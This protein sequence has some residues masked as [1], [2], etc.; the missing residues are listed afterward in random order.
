MSDAGSSAVPEESN[1]PRSRD[2]VA[3]TLIVAIS[4]SLVCSIFVSMSAVLLKPQ[5]IENRE[6]YRKQ[7]AAGGIPAWKAPEL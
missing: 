4:V 2:S 6:L 3:N 1:K 5:Q 7:M